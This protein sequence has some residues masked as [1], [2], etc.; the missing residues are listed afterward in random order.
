MLGFVLTE[1]P[2]DLQGAALQKQVF[3]RPLLWG[4]LY[5]FTEFVDFLSIIQIFSS[6]LYETKDNR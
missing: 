2:T 1:K 4:Y 6:R 3:E 5:A